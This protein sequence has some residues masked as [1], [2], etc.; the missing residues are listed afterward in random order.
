MPWVPKEKIIVPIDFSPS[1]A[2][3]IREALNMAR[4]PD[5]V[6]VV[7]VIPKLEVLSPGV[8]FGEI[9]DE[10]RLANAREYM[11]TYL[12]SHDFEGMHQDVLIG[13]PGTMIV[14]YA[15][16][17]DADLILIPSHGFHGV[18]RMLLGSVAERVIRHADCAVYVARRLD[19]E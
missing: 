11:A 5:C 16:D 3:A 19:A 18:K 2:P 8:L 17:A 15:D 13:D 10:K 12:A 1:S 4:A 6:Y 9:N 14:E 7:H